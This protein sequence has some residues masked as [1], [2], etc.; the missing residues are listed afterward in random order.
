MKVLLKSLSKLLL[1]K[2]AREL[3]ENFSN[4]GITTATAN[5]TGI[6]FSVC[7]KEVANSPEFKNLRKNAR[8]LHQ[9][10]R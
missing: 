2:E 6:G 10:S 3:A 4:A 1:S 5:K 7:A 9:T 8:I